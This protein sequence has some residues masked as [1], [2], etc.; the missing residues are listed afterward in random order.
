MGFMTKKILVADDEINVVTSICDLLRHWGFDTVA[1]YE[2]SEVV[3]KALRLRPDL[4]LMDLQMPDSVE[5]SVLSRLKA[6][7]ETA[8]IPVIIVSGSDVQKI[9]AVISAGGKADYLLKPFSAS[10]LVRKIHE[11]LAAT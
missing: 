5:T 8:R 7:P 10:Q 1:A 4:I 11:L 9:L 6:C 2:G 3:D